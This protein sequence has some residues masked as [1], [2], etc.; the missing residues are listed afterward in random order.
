MR[1]ALRPDR[2]T[3]L[4]RADTLTDFPAGAQTPAEQEPAWP[5]I[6]NS[7]SGLHNQA[8]QRRAGPPF[9][10]S[11]TKTTLSP[12]PAGLGEEWSYRPLVCT[13]LN[14]LKVSLLRAVEL[15]LITQLFHGSQ[16]VVDDGLELRA[17]QA[18]QHKGALTQD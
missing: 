15:V 9:S 13:S 14:E 4:Q 11:L 2:P 5:F 6:S 17:L 16:Q 1:L 3:H 7:V 12:E 10:S 8:S 18:L